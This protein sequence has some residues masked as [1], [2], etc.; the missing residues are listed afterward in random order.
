MTGKDDGNGRFGK[1]GERVGWLEKVWKYI[2]GAVAGSAV[3]AVVAVR[4][5]AR[6]DGAKEREAEFLRAEVATLR[7]EVRELRAIAPAFW[8]RRHELQGDD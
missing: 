7:A 6:A 3:T 1:L 4:E 8:M 2:A 5:D